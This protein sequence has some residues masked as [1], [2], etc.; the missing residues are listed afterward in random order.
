[1][2]HSVRV[3]KL[4][5]LAAVAVLVL[6]GVAQARR[7]PAPTAFSLQQEVWSYSSNPTAPSGCLN[8]DDSHYRNWAGSLAGTFL[9]TEQLCDYATDGWS[10]GG[11]GLEADV[12]VTDAVADL[13][14]T[15][16]AGVKQQAVLMSQ[17]KLKGGAIRNYYAVCVMPLFYLSTN[18]GTDPLPGGTWTFS[19][20]TQAS[21][22]SYEVRGIMGYPDQQQA[23]CPASEQNLAP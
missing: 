6:P 1:M 9:A 2:R 5:S 22:V 11:I 4:A 15:S 10:A 17:T 19:L 13:S 18:T 21:T 23:Y 7:S 3:L 12:W 20:T 8:E 16:P 14:I